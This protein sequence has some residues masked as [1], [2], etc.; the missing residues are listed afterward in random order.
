MSRGS[1]PAGGH[2]ARRFRGRSGGGWRPAGA[3]AGRGRG[4]R[5]GRE[6]GAGGRE[7]AGWRMGVSGVRHFEVLG[8][9]GGE[10][11]SQVAVGWCWGSPR[12]LRVQGG[13]RGV[14][15]LPDA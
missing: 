3:S 1:A 7:E 4:E 5:R 9:R 14:A 15:V 11:G 2:H 12:R 6:R 10:S 8:G 13:G